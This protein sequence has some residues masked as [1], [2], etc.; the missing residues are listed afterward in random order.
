MALD[1][2]VVLVYLVLITLFGLWVGRNSGKDSSSYFLGG[3]SFNWVLIGFSLFATNI[4]IGAFVGGSGLAARAGLAQINPELLGGIMLTVSAFIFIPLFIRTKIF[5]IPQFLELRYNR[6]AKLLFGGL[7]ACQFTLLMP[8]TMYAASKSILEL[9]RFSETSINIQIVALIIVM[10]VGMYSIFG[11][12]KAVVV[13]DFV[14]VLIML[15]GGFAV[16]IIALIRIGGIEGIQESIA[17]EQLELLR[18]RSDKYFPWTAVFPGQLLHSAFFAFCSIHILQRALGAKDVNAAQNGLLLGAFLKLFGIFLF[19]FPGIIGA[20]LFPGTEADNLYATMIRELLPAGFSGLVLA[21]M[22]AA[23]MSSQDSGINAIS[24]V[25]A[26]DIYPVFRKKCSESEAVLVGKIFA[27]STLLWGI[28]MA[29]LCGAF[30]EGIYSMILKI[31]GYMMLPTGVCYLMGRFFPRLNGTGAVV[32]L[33]T[34]LVINVYYVITSSVPDLN[35]LLPAIVR[36]MHF[37]ELYPILVLLLSGL[38]FAVSYLTA[39]P[40]PEKLQCLTTGD[41]PVITADV[42]FYKRFKFWW[43]FYLSIVAFLYIVF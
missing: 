13:T 26:L 2:T 41:R 37:Y 29:P 17:P 38:L 19:T 11:G 43:I 7:Y 23:M 1:L 6:S 28:L 27:G 15:T 8:I 31:S 16:M 12:L 39:P 33:A 14:Q 18:P 36:E 42:P 25:V 32:T 35:H 22:L 9:F 10:T 5:T 34:G 30:P 21:G 20:H 40:G 4:S 3:R 24:G